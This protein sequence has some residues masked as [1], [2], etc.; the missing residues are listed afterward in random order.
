MRKNPSIVISHVFAPQV[1]LDIGTAFTTSTASS[2]PDNQKYPMD[3]IKETTPCT[4]LYVKGTMLSTIEVLDAIVMLDHIVLGQPI[5]SEC[6]V[7]KMTTTTEG[8]EFNDL[9]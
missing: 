2:A 8:H 7:I 5:P 3:D 9:D 6:V 1:N 4:L